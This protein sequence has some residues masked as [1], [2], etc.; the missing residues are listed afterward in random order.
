MSN[1]YRIFHNIKVSWQRK[2]E[3]DTLYNYAAAILIQSYDERK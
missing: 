3:A 1:I 2:K